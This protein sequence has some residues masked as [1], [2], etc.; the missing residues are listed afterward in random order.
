MTTP[1]LNLRDEV[2]ALALPSSYDFQFL[3]YLMNSTHAC[4]A[5]DVTSPGEIE[6]DLY[7]VLAYMLSEP[8]GILDFTQSSSDN[9][10]VPASSPWRER[11]PPVKKPYRITSNR[12]LLGGKK[13]SP[14]SPV[15]CASFHLGS[16]YQHCM[17]IAKMGG[18]L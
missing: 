11:G 7:F 13:G 8:N 18:N 5:T 6:S 4:H 17:L 2:A 16:K 12:R 1:C 10:R 9:G 15:G 14:H 3:T